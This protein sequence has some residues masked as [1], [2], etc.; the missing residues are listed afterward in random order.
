MTLPPPHVTLDHCLPMADRLVHAAELSL[1]QSGLTDIVLPPAGGGGGSLDRSSVELFAALYF[2]AELEE[3]GLIRVAEFLADERS[4]LTL[5]DAAAARLLEDFAQRMRGPWYDARPRALVFARVF[6]LGAGASGDSAVAINDGFQSRFAALC[7]AAAAW[8]EAGPYGGRAAWRAATVALSAR[9]L[10]DDLAERRWGNTVA[11]GRAIQGQLADA[12]RLLDHAG[13]KTL[14]QA[15][16]M[17]ELVARLLESD[18]PA[19]SRIVTRG[20]SGMRIL[21]WLGERLPMIRAGDGLDADL[22]GSRD[23]IFW[24]RSWLE[25]SEIRV[26]SRGDEASPGTTER[27]GHRDIDA[28]PPE[29]RWA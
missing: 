4:S 12:V 21:A 22:A 23:F 26:E 5:R 2:Q 16:S 28:A 6:G 25:A 13:L 19:L 3:A 18:T 9:D 24:C 11:A 20:Q 8:A 29:R 15:R 17:W 14:F 10:L 7:R 27:P 1:A